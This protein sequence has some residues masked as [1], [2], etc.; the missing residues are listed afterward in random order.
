MAN[1]FTTII[2]GN[3]QLDRI[4]ANI[5]NAFNSQN[6]PFIGGVLLTNQKIGTGA[7][8]INHGLGR[9]PQIWVICDQNTNT[10]VWRTAWNSSSITLE[11]GS[12]CTIS[13]WVN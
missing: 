8:V 13:L 5:S 10:T 7:T 2:T 9:Q 1:P 4:Q 3:Q 11:A 12:D 6:G